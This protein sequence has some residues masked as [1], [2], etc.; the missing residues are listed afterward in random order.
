MKLI[1]GMGIKSRL[2]Q[3]VEIFS[4]IKNISDTI[5][6]HFSDEGLYSQGMTVDHCSV[7][8][9]NFDKEWFEEFKIESSD[10]KQITMRTEI[11]SK[12]LHTRQPNQFMVMSFENNPSSIKIEFKNRQDQPN[13]MEFPK[14][15]NIA[16]MDVDDE[17]L[18]IPKVDYSVE[19][20]IPSKI[21]T[22][23]NDQLAIF[24]ETISIHCN[25]ETIN[26]HVEGHEGSMVVP[27]FS[28][29]VEYVSEYSIEEDLD[30]KLDYSHKH[31]SHFC[32]FLKISNHVSLGFSKDVPMKFNYIF[33][34]E[35]KIK[36]SFYL[37]PKISDE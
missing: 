25:E 10:L 20:E 27:L 31:F 12:I 7:F 15:F 3:F 17:L 37:A 18:N 21:L 8:E 26:F 9:A 11:L 22:N 29:D 4:N 33:P 14:E 5:T 30:L 23:I 34:E 13:R 28:D 35:E 19:F 1:L 24:N 16:L 36:L 2:Q 32:K 6:F